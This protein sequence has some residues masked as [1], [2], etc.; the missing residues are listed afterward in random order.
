MSVGTADALPF[1]RGERP[2]G[3]DVWTATRLLTLVGRLTPERG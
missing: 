2:A 1:R 3:V